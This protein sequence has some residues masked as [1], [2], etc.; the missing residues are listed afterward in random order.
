MGVLNYKHKTF[1]EDCFCT[2]SKY[3]PIFCN[4]KFHKMFSNL[5]RALIYFTI[6]ATCVEPFKI[7]LHVCICIECKDLI[8]LECP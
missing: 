3:E 1:V 5:L 2:P 6:R 7:F 4:S 8:I